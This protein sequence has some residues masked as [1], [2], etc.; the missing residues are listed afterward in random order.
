MTVVLYGSKYGSTKQYAEWIAEE[1]NAD[2]FDV[3][4]AN[5]QNIKNYDTIIYGGAVY[6][7]GITGIN[8]IVKNYDQLKNA[9]LVIFTCGIADPSIDINKENLI[10]NVLK[11]FPKASADEFAL[12]HLRGAMD[13][14][15]MC[16]LHKTMMSALV[17]KIKNKSSLTD[18]ERCILD[19]YGKTVDFVDKS[20]IWPIIRYAKENPE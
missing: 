12:F 4:D 11:K 20:T 18:E 6:A 15:K 17:K 2:L 14:S 5:L 8:F 13:Y 7:G 9:K 3:N 10:K 1:L 16:F 19:T